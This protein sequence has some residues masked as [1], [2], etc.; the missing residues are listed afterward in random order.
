MRRAGEIA[1][2]LTAADGRRTS[3]VAC[4]SFDHLDPT[5]DHTGS[6]HRLKSEHG[7]N[8]PLDCTMVL[9]DP[10]VQIGALPGANGFQI[11]PRS[12][13]EPVCGITGQDRLTVSLTA[14][15]DNPLGP[16]MPFKRLAQEPFGGCKIAPLAEP[17]L[18]GVAAAVNRAVQVHPPPTHLDIGLIDMPPSGDG[19]LA[20][21][22]L[23][24][25]E[26][27]VMNGPAMDRRVID[28]DAPLGHHFFQVPQAEIVGQVPADAEQDHGSIKMPALKHTTLHP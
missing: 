8:P 27:R 2:R 22:E 19:S 7:S 3:P 12:V 4:A 17:K 13:L 5:Q 25:Q 9:L 6:G 23:L 28:G 26:R 1:R 14:V 24:E 10:V 15:D 11:M 18:N 21:I 20:P 16:A